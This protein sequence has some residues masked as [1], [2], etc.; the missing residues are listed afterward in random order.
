M[1][2]RVVWPLLIAPLPG[3]LTA[4]YAWQIFVID[5]GFSEPPEVPAIE[6]QIRVYVLGLIA[7]SVVP[8]VGLAGAR[9]TSRAGW[10]LRLLAFVPSWALAVVALSIVL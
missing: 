5:I 8:L 2:F 9:S 7:L 4:L 10:L 6:A 1:P 3:V